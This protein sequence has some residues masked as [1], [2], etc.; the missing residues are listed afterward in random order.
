KQPLEQRKKALRDFFHGIP[1]KGT[2]R[3][4]PFTH[5]LTGA[6]RWMENLATVGFDGVVAKRADE[7]YHSGDRAGMV[8]VKR[9]RTADCVVGGFRFASKGKVVGSLLLGLYD[10]DGKLNHVGFSSSFKA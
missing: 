1:K 8:K 2:V 5:D 7:P 10:A 3:L 4:S 9:L 6:R